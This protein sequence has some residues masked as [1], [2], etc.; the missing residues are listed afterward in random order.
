LIAAGVARVVVACGDPDPRVAGGGV[1]R[2]RA[3]GVEVVTGVLEAQAEAAHR[4]FFTRVRTGR[5]M[6]T[7][8][9]AMS[10]DGRIATASGDSQWITGPEARRR[11]HGMRADHDAVL[12]GAGTARAD[13]P[14][15][16]VRGFG[17][18][19]QPVR[20]VVSRRLDVAHDGQLGRTARQVPV[21]LIHGADAPEAARAAWTAQGARLL[22]VA[23][24]SGG[25]VDLSAALRVLGDEGLTRVFCEGG[26]TLA[27][28]LLAGD[29]VDRLAIFSGGLMLG[30]E[31][32]P[33][34]GALGIS[35]L[36]EAQTWALESVQRVGPD[37]LSI[38]LR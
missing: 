33:G 14:S 24:L 11:V 5:P 20:V 29:L 26:G 15:L 31:G 21:W 25:Q 4:G 35:A 38:W 12:V 30:A 8:K 2:L 10:L 27:A 13:D 17:D 28:S 9:L 1:A 6:V 19:A 18:V 32:K 23:S 36:A 37:T 3:A 7:L 34:V 16:T 22:E